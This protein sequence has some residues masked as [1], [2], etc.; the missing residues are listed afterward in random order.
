M[1][2]R[3]SGLRRPRRSRQAVWAVYLAVI[4]GLL[5]AALVTPSAAAPAAPGGASTVGDYVWLDY[6]F[7]GNHTGA[8]NASEA[9]Y[10]AGIPG[11]GVTLELWRW[12]GTAWVLDGT[13][14]TNAVGFYQFPA[15][16]QATQYEVRLA[17]SNFLPG[18]PLDGYIYT[19]GAVYSPVFT[20]PNVLIYDYKN[21]D[22][23]FARSPLQVSKALLNSSPYTVVGDTITFR[24]TVTNSSTTVTLNPVPLDDFYSP[25]CLT[26]V[27]ASVAPTTVDAMLGQLHWDNVGPLGPGQSVIID[28]QFTAA[29]SQAMAWKEGG[30]QDYAPKGI[31]DFDQ[32]QVGWDAPAG[33]G[34][35]WYQ[36]GPVAAANSLWWFDSKFEP[37]PLAPP[38]VNDNYPLVQSYEPAN[39]W[40]DHDARNVAPLVADL[41]TLMGTTAGTG[42]TVTGLASGIAQFIADA[43]LAQEYTVTTQAKPTFAWVGDEV[44]RSEDVVLLL[45]FWQESVTG[46]PAKRVGGHYVT[47]SGVDLLNSIVAFSDPYRDQAEATGAG[48]VLPGA[49]PAL[50]PA[51]GL[52]G[53]VIHNDAQYISQDAY[54]STATALPAGTWGPAAYVDASPATGC[55]QIAN[56][57]GQNVPAE[58]ATVQAACDPAGGA[59]RTT[60]EYAVAV[61]PIANTPMCS[62]TTNIAAVTGA[63][64]EGSGFVLPPAQSEA[65]VTQGADWGDLPEP[66]HPTL[67]ASNGPRHLITSP[68]RLGRQVDAEGNGQPDASARG[69]DNNGVPDDE[70]GVDALPGLTGFWDEGTVAGGF[71]GSLEI[72][73][74]GG[75]GVPEVFIGFNGGALAAITLRDATG[76]PLPTTPW[77]PGTY[78]VYLDIPAGAMGGSPTIPVR[79]RLS[80]AGGL[81]ATGPAPDGEVE[82]YLFQFTPNAVAVSELSAEPA[83]QWPF[84]MLGIVLGLGAWLLR[85][86][87]AA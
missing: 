87:I 23:G 47:V 22:F 17:E 45:G 82:D 41:S 49:H 33:S 10:T 46:A 72:I 69:D 64:V 35:G 54:A 36:C 63:T 57:Q 66:Q 80:S 20:M 2:T 7:D 51:P 28:V 84:L 31:P 62:P 14:T 8:G 11:A 65:S 30:W 34:A 29:N 5:G 86:R 40:D 59:L 83:G 42:T 71:G 4:V 78:Q 9:E 19:S 18:G 44:R 56:F 38:A 6:N 52:D 16:A 55:A 15:T 75:S 60:I 68:L 70:D 85:R 21:A 81:A 24:I 13:T 48:R 12:N 73:I 67:A 26:Y 79:V 50:H 74:S 39:A 76:A 1:K 53:E 32:R 27:T 58:F 3:K 43:G 37:A 77:L 61:S 25:A